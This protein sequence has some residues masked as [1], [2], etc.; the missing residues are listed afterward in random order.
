MYAPGKDGKSGFLVFVRGT[1][2]VAQ[3][4][5]PQTLTVTGDALALA[6]STLNVIGSAFFVFSA[7][8]VS[9]NGVLVTEEYS[10]DL[11]KL[12]WV[13]R[14]GKPLN[15]PLSVP[16]G[17]LSAIRLSPDQR[18]LAFAQRDV[19]ATPPRYDIWLHDLA[20]GA[21]LRFTFEDSNRNPLW[22]PDGSRI[23]FTRNRPEF[24][25]YI[26]DIGSNRIEELLPE[27]PGSKFPSDWSHDGRF[28]AFD[29]V[30]PKS[31]YDIWIV[32]LE[33][34]R[35]PVPFLESPFEDSRAHFSP[36]GRWLAYQTDETGTRSIYIRPFDPPGRPV[37][38]GKW[39]ISTGG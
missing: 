5:D 8:S 35:K 16:E 39:H 21:P 13:D 36:N 33:G 28:I 19:P 22:S 37:R 30:N 18:R 29:W 25:L 2:L 9:A 10:P 31:G 26:K 34:D 20:R 15:K 14:T 17:E 6:E 4:F 27:S 23:L 7:F 38:T 24:G 32:P 1:T 11:R 12:V 3:P